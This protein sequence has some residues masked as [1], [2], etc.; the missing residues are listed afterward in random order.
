MVSAWTNFWT[1]F[2]IFNIFTQFFHYNIQ[3]IISEVITTMIKQIFKGSQITRNM[4]IPALA[5]WLVKLSGLI[6]FTSNWPHSCGLKTKISI[7]KKK[8]Y[9]TIHNEIFLLMPYP[10]C[11]LFYFITSSFGYI[12]NEFTH[13][14]WH[15][16]TDTWADCASVNSFRSGGMHHMAS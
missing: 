6:N 13:I 15:C 11:A 3:H 10:V 8:Y 1:K 16:F 12:Y 14:L 9:S 7:L 5:T 2:S 4:D